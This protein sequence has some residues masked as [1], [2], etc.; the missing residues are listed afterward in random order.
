MTD[1]PSDQMH[2]FDMWNLQLCFDNDNISIQPNIASTSSHHHHSKTTFMMIII[3]YVT[4][5]LLHEHHVTLKNHC[6]HAYKLRLFRY[7]G[8]NAQLIHKLYLHEL[9]AL[10]AK[11]RWREG[12][13]RWAYCSESWWWWWWWRFSIYIIVVQLLHTHITSYHHHHHHFSCF[14]NTVHN[15]NLCYAVL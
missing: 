15:V 1:P 9:L 11:W 13:L 12:L 7:D 5:I 8:D 4:N 14:S 2:W 10:Q 3:C 6:I